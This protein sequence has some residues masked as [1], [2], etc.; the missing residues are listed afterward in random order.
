M[1]TQ[2]EKRRPVFKGKLDRVQLAIWENKGREGDT[3]YSLSFSRSF[4]K[5][6]KNEGER[7]WQ[8]TSTFSEK[9]LP[10]LAQAIQLAAEWLGRQ[11]PKASQAI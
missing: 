8:Q 3:F 10:Q 5:P 2:D 6:G 4:A 1:T 7:T 11:E 9:D